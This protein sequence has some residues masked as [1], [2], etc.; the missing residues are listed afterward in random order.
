MSPMS[1]AAMNSVNVAKAGVASG[2]LSMNRMVG[3][4]LGV[5]VTGAIFQSLFRGRLHEQ[6]DGTTLA[7]MPAGKLFEAVSSGQ[8]AQLTRGVPKE[9]AQQVTHVARD[10]FIHALAGSLRLSM[11]IVVVGGVVAAFL[12]E[13][14]RLPKRQPRAED[15]KPEAVAE[16]LGA[17]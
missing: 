12:I 15:V 3:G 14:R 8:T 6:V 9:Q 4:S 2:I 5:A 10:A 7:K 1:T 11:V 13:G 16:P 17:Q